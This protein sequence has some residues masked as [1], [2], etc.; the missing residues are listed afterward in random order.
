V[1]NP[2][3]FVRQAPRE[4]LLFLLFSQCIRSR[5]DFGQR[6][7]TLNPP[8]QKIQANKLERPFVGHNV[9]LSQYVNVDSNNCSNRK[10]D[11]PKCLTTRNLQIENIA[12][13]RRWL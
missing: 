7:H 8:L 3:A 4:E 12:L 13:L 1:A 2:T 10:Q 9:P 5:F 11:N 6:R